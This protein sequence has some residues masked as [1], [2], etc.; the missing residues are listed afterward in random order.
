MLVTISNI[1]TELYLHSGRR[2]NIILQRHQHVP[3]LDV[4]MDKLLAVDILKTLG[5]MNQ[6]TSELRLREPET[7][8]SE[9]I[10][11]PLKTS[12]LAVLVLYVDLKIAS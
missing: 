9:V 2:G 7:A 1:Y 12:S 10:D 3:W 4:E 5:N 6:D 8:V 11:L